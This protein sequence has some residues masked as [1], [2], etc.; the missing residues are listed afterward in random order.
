MIWDSFRIF[1]SRNI[2]PLRLIANNS[3]AVCNNILLRKKSWFIL[4]VSLNFFIKIVNYWPW[5]G[6]FCNVVIQI[7][8]V[9]CRDHHYFLLRGGFFC[10]SNRLSENRLGTDCAATTTVTFA[11]S[12]FAAPFLALW[13]IGTAFSL[14]LGSGAFE[15]VLLDH[16]SAVWTM[17]GWWARK[18]VLLGAAWTVSSTSTLALWT[19]EWDPAICPALGCWTFGSCWTSC[20][21]T[22]HFNPALDFK[23]FWQIWHVNLNPSCSTDL[24]ISISAVR[25]KVESQIRHLILLMRPMSSKFRFWL[26]FET[27][28]SPTEFQ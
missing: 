15:R 19:L 2:A 24:C 7:S 4:K 1:I 11:L 12:G 16:G 22:W 17:L 8:S 23:A 27:W 10:W 20:V 28:L 18:R 21:F 9:A 26:Q 25:V 14:A 6:P 3:I 5:K 13:P